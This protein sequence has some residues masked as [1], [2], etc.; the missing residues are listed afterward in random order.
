MSAS[1]ALQEAVYAVLSADTAL[2]S[3][4]GD[5]ARIYDDVP[6]DAAFP[7]LTVAEGTQSEWGSQIDEGAEHRLI[8]HAWSRYAGRREVKQIIERVRTILHA[9]VLTLTGHTLI[10]L[11][12]EAIDFT[13]ANDARSYHAMARFRAVTE[14]P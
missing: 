12:C 1:L 5:P 7:Y 2:K 4:I 9:G 14:T 6:R 13:R 8:V 3:L 10:N 11:R